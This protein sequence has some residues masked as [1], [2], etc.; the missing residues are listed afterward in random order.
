MLHNAK[1]GNVHLN[2]CVLK[3]LLEVDPG[4]SRKLSPD[5]MRSECFSKLG[6][7]QLIPLANE[8]RQKM[9]S[10]LAQA[11]QQAASSR[12]YMKSVVIRS[13]SSGYVRI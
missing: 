12:P 4:D 13:G 7:S 6:N 11:R 5:A 1:C 8:I 3:N 2:P 10:S 9:L